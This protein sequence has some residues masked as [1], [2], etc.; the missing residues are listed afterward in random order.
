MTRILAN[1]MRRKIKVARA[2]EKLLWY[3]YF[4]QN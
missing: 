3:K 1:V 4:W 2:S